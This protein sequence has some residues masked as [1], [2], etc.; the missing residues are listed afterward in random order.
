MTEE[1]NTKNHKLLI[2][3]KFFNFMER[4]KFK[5]MN[6]RFIMAQI[7]FL[8]GSLLF[9]LPLSLG[10]LNAIICFMSVILF[11][12]GGLLVQLSGQWKIDNEVKGEKSGH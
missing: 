5:N 9:I 12:L 3:L 1:K 6:P 10:N 7:C 2:W 8:I 4:R 11:A